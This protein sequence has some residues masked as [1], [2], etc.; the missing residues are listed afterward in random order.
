MASTAK[1]LAAPN[2]RVFRPSQLRKMKGTEQ[3]AAV[4]FRVQNRRIEF[5]LVQ[6]GGGRWTFPKGSAEPGLTRAQAAALEAFEE[7]GVHGRMEETSF[8]RYTLPR[9]GIK[10]SNSPRSNSSQNLVVHAHL[11]EV[12]R[13]EAPQE[14]GRNP[15][16]FSPEKSIR[17]L[18]KHRPSDQGDE[19]ALVVG[20]AVDRVRGLLSGVNSVSNYSGRDALRKVEFEVLDSAHA[21]NWMGRAAFLA[22]AGR[23]RRTGNSS[24][25]ELALQTYLRRVLRNEQHQ[26]TQRSA[27]TKKH[28][29]LIGETTK[30]TPPS[31]RVLA[32]VQRIDEPTPRNRSRSGRE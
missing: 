6:T 18:R 30:P 27:G 13:L 31:G 29:L 3:V 8:A 9:E 4:C 26:S 2:M 20:A 28:R 19:L 17:R 12:S 23:S 5:L 21:A 16:W 14:D 32:R 15:T 11:C 22:Y 7:A 10:R 1:T 25:I 24:A